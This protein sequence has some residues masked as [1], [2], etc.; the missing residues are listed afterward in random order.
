MRVVATVVQLTPVIQ[1]IIRLF[2]DQIEG[3]GSCRSGSMQFVESHPQHVLAGCVSSKIAYD[4]EMNSD[5]LV[6]NDHSVTI[7]Y[8]LL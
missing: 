4:F 6:G 8:Y 3:S 5:F 7:N 2:L 1:L